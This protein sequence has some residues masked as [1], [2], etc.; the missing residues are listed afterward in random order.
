VSNLEVFAVTLLLSSDV[1][2]IA[3]ESIRIPNLKV[4]TMRSLGAVVAAVLLIVE[5]ATGQ[6][7]IGLAGGVNISGAEQSNFYYSRAYSTIGYVIGGIVDWPVSQN[8]SLL[9]EPTYVEKGTYAQPF[10]Y[11]GIVPKVSFDLSYLELPVLLKYSVGKDLKPYLLAGPSFGINLSSS[12]GAQVKGP[13][14]GQL[15]VMANA[16]S[17]VKNVECSLE[18]GGGLSYQI[19][20]LMVLFFEA[21]YSRSVTNTM[22]EGTFVMSLADETIGVEVGKADYKN[23]GIILLFGFTLP[24]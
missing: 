20:E 16:S 10:S 6:A 17:V 3:N 21:R 5:I 13:W 14:F 9:V 24:L 23:K 8:L 15:E 19:D 11:A 12:V 4:Q 7:R 2:G 22:N 1:L 18:F